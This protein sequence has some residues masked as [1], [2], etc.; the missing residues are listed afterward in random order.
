MVLITPDDFETIRTTVGHLARQTIANRIELVICAPSVDALRLDRGAVTALHSVRLVETGSFEVSG[1]VRALAARSASAPIL[2]YGEDHCYPDP[3]W[4]EALL[5]AHRAPHAAIAPAIRNANPESTVSWADLFTGYGPWIAPGRAGVVG[6]LPGH[7]TS[8]KRD[9]LLSYGTELDTLMEAET[10]LFWDLR[11]RGHTLYFETAAT[12]AHVNFAR[13]GVWLPVQWHL[14]RVFAATRAL[15]WSPLRRLAFALASPAL[16]V[17]R[18]ARILS[19]GIGNGV[20][21]GIL[22]RVM[23]AL[24]AGLA[25]DAVAQASG[26]LVG[27]GRSTER[28]TAL[29][30]HRLRVNQRGATGADVPRT[31]RAPMDPSPSSR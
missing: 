14:G 15:G 31:R 20:G 3:T 1:P 12:V 24:V 29:E 10:V 22:A 2:A 25:V 23:P 5:A 11:R 13:W 17:V 21:V 27:A 6:L 30:F 16:P 28:L 8:Y 26:C 9:V 18:L 4:A 7:N 19:S